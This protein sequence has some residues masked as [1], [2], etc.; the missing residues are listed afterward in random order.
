MATLLITGA[1]GYIGQR[2]AAM[3]A[4]AGHHVRTL[5][6]TAWRLSDTPAPETF[7]DVDAVVHLAHSWRNETTPHGENVN[8]SGS[9]SLARAARM[10]GVKRFIFVSSVSA[11]PD[12]RNIYGRIKY[13]TEERLLALAGAQVACARVG[14]VYGGKASGQYGVMRKLAR[15][16]LL[17]MMGLGQ[18]V[19]PIHLDEVCQGLLALGAGPPPSRPRTVLAAPRPMRF[20]RWLRLLHRA[21]TGRGFMVLIPVPFAIMLLASRVLAVIPF[22]P[23][24]DRERILGLAGTQ[25]CPSDLES[26]DVTASDPAARLVSPR[27]AARARLIESRILQHYLQGRRPK[28]GPVI[29]L[30]RL[31]RKEHE[32][33]LTFPGLLRAWPALLRLFDPVRATGALARH[34]QLAAMV[35][36]SS[37]PARGSALAQILLEGLALPF[38]L[39]LGWVLR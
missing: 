14:L 39:A 35:M 16:A 37:P 1:G 33:A 8:L 36:P 2:L 4:A 31:M 22:A 24:L 30:A 29:R 27:F 7:Q 20:A 13:A 19:Q 5:E 12:A 10:A 11:R 26:L 17:P 23:K 38:R 25:F 3:A 28:R 18:E 32:T 21:E 34:L 9:E 15:A 6:G